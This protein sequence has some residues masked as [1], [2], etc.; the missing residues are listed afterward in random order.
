[1]LICRRYKILITKTGLSRFIPA[2]AAT[3][4]IALTSTA[5]LSTGHAQQATPAATQP[6]IGYTIQPGEKLIRLGKRLLTNPDAWPEVASYNKLGNANAL[7]P[8]QTIELPLRLLKPMPANGKVVSVSGD[9]QL[10][11]SPAAAGTVLAEG[12]RLQ[13][14]ANSSAVIELA[15]GSRVTLLPNTLAE[16]A[17]SQNYATR[18]A[19]S[20][21]STTWFSGL[22]RLVQGSLD[23][24]ASKLARRA[25]PLQIQTPTSLVG[26]RGTQFRVAFDDPA[27]QN[28]RTEVLEGLVQADNLAQ[29]SG[30]ALPKGK[31]AVL[32]PAVKEITVVDLL[33]APDL[34]ATPADI[35]KPLALWPMPG[36]EGAAS[37]RVQVAS[38]ASFNQIVRD[39]VVTA[40]SADL[41][42]LDNGSWFARIRG[43][44]AVGIEGYDSIK[45]VRVAVAP[46]R[47]W[48]IDSDRIDLNN[49]RH[50][51]RFTQQG[52]NA[53]HTITASVSAEQAPSTT[54]VE[55]TV[56]ASA[57]EVQLDLGNLQAGAPYLLRM[58]VV[59]R[60]GAEVVALTYR[61]VGL[62]G[63]GWVR[64]TLELV[65]P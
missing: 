13:T 15:D 30:A 19:R 54:I 4:S 52:L 17:T 46:P 7:R 37:F 55:T 48:R 8:G 44:D 11:T 33:K 65:R 24:A 12:A 64:N 47:Q 58:T 14:G 51:L 9:V 18:D 38:D 5:F 57:D 45:T 23:T 32:N 31:G 27:T 56:I 16:L 49:G 40:G 21:A 62:S 43:I 60:D 61:F 59:Q 1:M 42:S 53:D 50:V 25:T 35:F 63:S 22:I 2:L 26:V 3:I 29:G 20:S 10:G 34:S 28:A 41:A 39:L 36:L 6:S